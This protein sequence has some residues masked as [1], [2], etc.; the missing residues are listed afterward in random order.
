MSATP[1]L[2]NGAKGQ[3]GHFVE[4]LFDLHRPELGEGLNNEPPLR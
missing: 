1:R 4:P 2:D 3:G